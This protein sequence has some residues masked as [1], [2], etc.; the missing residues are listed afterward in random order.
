MVVRRQLLLNAI[1]FQ[2]CWFACV[3][4]GSAVA[5]PV[6]GAFVAWQY[7]YWQPAEWRL[8]LGV[9]LAG[10]AM[11][12]LWLHSG[13]MT[14]ADPSLPIIPLWL[15]LLWLAFAATLLHSLQ[16]LMSKPL[17]LGVASLLAAPLSYYAGSRTGALQLSESALPAIAAGWGILMLTSALLWRRFSC[18]VS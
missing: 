18:A 9:T 1:G 6:V 2:V 4:G 15:A 11:D 5:L 10:I 7:R 12:S 14:F 13:L 16:W 3:F 17:L 8:L